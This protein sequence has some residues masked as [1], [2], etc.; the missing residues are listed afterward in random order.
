M[1]RMQLL[2][3]AGCILYGLLLL[4]QGIDSPGAQNADYNYHDSGLGIWIDRFIGTSDVV[5]IPAQIDNRPV[6]GLNES[7]FAGSS[8]RSVTIPDGLTSYFPGIFSGCVNLT[9]VVLPSNV[10][11]IS[12]FMFSGCRNL[13]RISLPA[14]LQGIGVAGF[15][16]S[17]LTNISLPSSVVD[18]QTGAFYECG[19]LLSATIGDGLGQI[20][21]A[22]FGGCSNLTNVRIGRA[23]SRI[24]GSAFFGCS[25]LTNFVVNNDNGSLSTVD[26]ILFN[27]VRSELIRYPPGKENAVYVVPSGVT[28]IATNAF[29]SSQKLRSVVLPESL[30][31]IRESAFASVPLRSVIIPA[32]V[33]EIGTGAFDFCDFGTVIVRS[34][35]VAFASRSFGFPLSLVLF[36]ANNN[37]SFHPT[38]FSDSQTIYAYRTG[39]S[40]WSDA[41]VSDKPV[42]PWKD[43]ELNI[44]SPT[45]P[46]QID[47][48]IRGLSGVRIILEA[49]GPSLIW[50]AVLTN[51]LGENGLSS[52][53]PAHNPGSE[54]FRARTY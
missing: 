52:T 25:Q 36:E 54:I 50:N 45:N 20:S 51:R 47:F 35:Q 31:R 9:N 43:L 37:H 19:D 23:V 30:L 24:A 41:L 27:E 11:G 39:T 34:P 16:R 44:A 8:I 53:A 32:S 17:G 48:R 28:V 18:I 49:L 38:A 33:V 14:S 4:L 6:I 7:A 3:K 40:G 5:S 21:E 22:V 2:T 46:S 29:G 1:G 13:R 42:L 26:G 15:I 12:Q 10:S